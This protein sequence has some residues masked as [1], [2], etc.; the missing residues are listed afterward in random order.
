MNNITLSDGEWKLMNAL[1]DNSPCSLSFLVKHFE[2]DT[3]WSKSTIFI[4]LKRLME[5]GAVSIDTSGKV[6]LYSP[7]ID[8]EDATVKETKSF[9]SRI[10][11]GSVGLMLSSLAGQRSLS[12]RDIE[13]L[14]K[15]LDEV[16][17]N[18]SKED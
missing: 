17:S 8:R 15:V 12:E 6:Q 14:R 13:E 4:M 1:W 16:E 10:Y 11:G 5:K 18:I 2:G 3:D 9:L 7:E